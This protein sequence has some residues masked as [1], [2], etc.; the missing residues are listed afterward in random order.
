MQKTAPFQHTKLALIIATIA[1]PAATLAGPMDLVQYPPGSAYKTPIPNV[2][3]SI[4]TSGSMD[5]TDSGMTKSRLAFVREGLKNTLIQKPDGTP[6]TKYDN[7]FRL[8]WQSYRCNNIPSTTGNCNNDNAIAK[9]SGT[10]KT[11]FATWAKNL[12]SGTASG[13]TNTP[14]HMLVWNAGEYL[15]T[16]GNN[17]P[18]NATPGTS[19][20]Q[21]LDCRKAYHIFLTDGGWNYSTP[22]KWYPAYTPDKAGAAT[23]FSFNTKILA[24]DPYAQEIQNADGKLKNLPE[25]IKKAPDVNQF[26][27]TTNGQLKVYS[28]S[29]TRNIKNS[30][31]NKDYV[32]PSLADMAFHYWATDLQPGI[33][34]K[35]SPRI[36]KSGPEKFTSGTLENTI[37]EEW[38]PK[39]NPATWQHL[40]QYIVGYG[41][42]ASTLTKNTTTSPQFTGGM[43][44]SGFTDLVVGKTKWDN[45]IGTAADGD[46]DD[47]RPQDMWHM[48]I[49]SR[50]KFYPV[51]GGDLTSVFSDIFDDLIV[52]TSA[53]ISGF[54][55]ASGSV[56]RTD[57]QSYQT[58]YVAAEDKNS[59]D[60]RWFGFVTSDTLSTT[61]DATPN[62]DWG[63]IAGK[64]K[65]TAD[66]LSE[67]SDISTRLILSYDF[68]ASTDKGISF[69]WAN[70]SETPD[71][72]TTASAKMWLNNGSAGTATTIL[73]D[74]RGEDRLNFIRGDRSKEALNDTS[75]A[76][77]K[78]RNRKS[79]QGDIVNSTVWYVG[80]PASGYAAGSY[81][82]FAST[83]RT[84][85]PMIYVGGN[86]GMLHGFS[87]K[88]GTE[89]IA[90]V[91]H[92]VIQN[93]AKLTD[94]NYD[95]RYFVDGSPMSGD[96]N[97][98]AAGSPDWRT[99]LV[100]TLGAGGRGFF[101]L[102]VTKSGPKDASST[103]PSDFTEGKAAALVVMDKT[104]AAT[105]D[106]APPSKPEDPN[107]HPDIGHIM[108]EPPVSESNQQRALQITQMND[109]RWAFISGNG[110]NS[111]NEKPVLLIQYLDGDKSLKTIQ[112]SDPACPVAVKGNGLSAPQF[113]DINGDGIPDM[114]YAGDLCGNIWKFDISSTTASNWGVAFGGTPLF[115][116]QYTNS[117][118]G[119]SS[120]QPI[121]TAPVLRPNRKVGGLMVAFGTG[122]N[123]TEGD[124]T[125]KSVQTVYSVLDNTRYTVE[126]TGA[127]KGRVRIKTSAP[128]PS[129]VSNGR[130]D[131]LK[132]DVINGASAGTAGDKA[133][134]GREFWKLST[135]EVTYVCEAGDTVCEAKIKKGWYLDL[136]MA[137]ERVTKNIGFFDGSNILEIMSEVPASGSATA[138]GDEV[139]APQPSVAKPFRTLI[140]ISS[141]TPAKP[142]ILD[143]N[144]DGVYKAADDGEYARMT[145]SSKELRFTTKDLQ[146]RKG[147]DGKT[148]KLA[149]LP[150]LLL[151]PSWRQLK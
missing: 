142:P 141:G 50:G 118:T 62:A 97:L 132:Q 64:H 3:L 99:L 6:V 34:N 11:T 43:Y 29:Y 60:N 30:A 88:D 143:V 41:P 105:V 25:K 76:S 66:K 148:D 120:R 108:G 32:Y 24:T 53:P 140:N 92:G 135:E 69:K 7:K 15:K 55:S 104:A 151:R 80:E 121:T 44:G 91:P 79:I 115:T 126:T 39:N 103:V 72:A 110:Y 16:T 78:F 38:N 47:Y 113:L 133:S 134:L 116:A 138:G 1:T 124:R 75:A 63:L 10:H 127:D 85:M 122:Q 150:E 128:T 9:F 94:P 123:L 106:A 57:T 45:V 49:N 4:D 5:T 93:L 8:A 23:A 89:K 18:W 70:F 46:Y 33:A 13:T 19:D 40:V 42:K 125:E 28:D 129:P 21:P 114:V 82:S 35:L 27:P 77:I 81:K 20:S 86:D 83:Y 96:V 74:G 111:V 101:V 68:L 59:N 36:T 147:N 84:R 37:D 90:Y 139:C 112:P 146:I 87:A 67:L 102:D 95:H 137:G 12:T 61:G 107:A 98:G 117:A 71:P 145:A 51:S 136:P 144:G 22:T 52:D 26:D 119:S 149:K 131:L 54:T 65:T 58:T 14:S 56:S 2:I 17:S 109:G 48:A 31:N 73:G 100:G 130:S